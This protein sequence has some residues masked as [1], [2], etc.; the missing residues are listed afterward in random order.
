MCDLSMFFNSYSLFSL[1]A[2]HH[3]WFKKTA[4]HVF[5]NRSPPR[6]R[7]GVFVHLLRLVSDLAFPKYCP[8]ST[9]H[10]PLSTVHCPLST[11]HCPLSTVHCPLSTVHCPLSA[12]NDQRSYN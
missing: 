5:L 11:V 4:A 2:P 10:C 12:V 9:V 6:L 1:H 7:R 8:L 3:P